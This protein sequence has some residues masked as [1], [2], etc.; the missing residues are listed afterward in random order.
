MADATTKVTFK[1]EDQI[2]P[3]VKKIT[4][5]L[6]KMNSMNFTKLSASFAIVVTAAKQVASGIKAIYSECSAMVNEFSK[7]E[8]LNTRLIA[9]WKNVGSA[10]GMTAEQLL[11]YADALEKV[12]FFEAESIQAAAQ[13][14]AATQALSEKGFKRALDLSVDLAE[15]MGTDVPNAASVLARALIAPEQGLGRLK[16]IGVAFDEQEQLLIKRL[17]ESGQQLEAQEIILGK[18]EEKYGGIAQA[19]AE[20]NTNKLTQINNTV[21][22]IRENIGGALLDRLSPILDSL[23]AKLQKIEAW[24]TRNKDTGSILSVA[25]QGGSLSTYSNESLQEALKQLEIRPDWGENSALD[26]YW[27]KINAELNARTASSGRSA[28]AQTMFSGM[29]TYTAPVTV[30]EEP[31]VAV[32]EKTTQKVSELSTF[33]EKN[34]SLS[35]TA[36]KAYL[37]AQIEQATTYALQLDEGTKELDMMDEIIAKLKEQRAAL[38][39]TSESATKL[40]VSFK[41]TFTKVGSYVSKGVESVSSFFSAM[42]TQQAETLEQELEDMKKNGDLTEE[43]EQRKLETI[44]NLKKKAFE[45][46][47][48][49][50]I[51]Q[52]VISGAQA[53][54]E[55][56]ANP[57]G[58]AG[59]ALA[60][61]SAVTTALQVATIKQQQYTPMATGGIVTQPT[62]I[63]AGEAGAEAI[64]PLENARARGYLNT[65]DNKPVVINITVQGNAD[66]EVIFNAIERAQRTGYLPKWRYA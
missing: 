63:L 33:L 45:A 50:S 11:N 26:A 36:Q 46:D 7:V 44:N 39:E 21:G 38:D 4:N 37:D 64:I 24:S 6:E 23:Y 17:Q 65:E 54:V 55:F 20:I 3:E 12:T 53:A 40:S 14:L 66:E 59:I 49:N 56:L 1:G 57:G 5:Q 51:A 52:A 31:T 19:V 48:Q 22:T 2:T 62:N 29:A 10:T 18:V 43:E 13:T 28:A 61:A 34:R 32:V 30:Q 41:D 16:T 35:L 9:T 47:K 58:Y 60:A 27:N 8:H 15:A 42:Y 25:K